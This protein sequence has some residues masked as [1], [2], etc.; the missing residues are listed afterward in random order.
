[1]IVTGPD[2]NLWFSGY[3]AIGLI[4]T[5][6]I[7]TLISMPGISGTRAL[8][9]D[10]ERNLW[11]AEDQK[12]GRLSSDGSI[13]EFT[14]PG[15]GRPAG[16]TL[17]PD[18]RIWFTDVAN[19]RI[20]SISAN[21]SLSE[22]Q[23]STY[24]GAI[25]A[26]PDGNLWFA[27]AG[28]LIVRVT[29]TGVLTEFSVPGHGNP[30]N[31]AVAITAGADGALWFTEPY[32]AIGRITT[33]G[34]V[35]LFSIPRFQ[36]G[37]FIGGIAQGQD[38]NLWFTEYVNPFPYSSATPFARIGQIDQEGTINQFSLPSAFSGPTDIA[39]GP[40]GSLWVT[41]LYINRIA[42]I[43]PQRP[44]DRFPI[45]LFPRGGESR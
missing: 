12:I 11:F 28:D 38:G 29:P 20:G 30:Y 16:M 19:Q 27:E 39:V 10:R 18:D 15:A 14:L 9:F 40:D 42:R 8:V 32:G 6:G 24:P 31:S 26:G 5:T 43:S 21:G 13:A 37:E 35:S 45:D 23:L 17:G 4:T 7:V 2:G 34:D 41:E 1:M 3:P 25:A 44:C 36:S 22:I 33:T